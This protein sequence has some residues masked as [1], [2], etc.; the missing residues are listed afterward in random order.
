MTVLVNLIFCRIDN[1]DG[2]IFGGGGG[3]NGR[4]YGGLMF[5]MLLGLR[6]CGAHI[7]GRLIYGGVLTE[8]YGTCLW[9]A[10]SQ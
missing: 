7:C 2:P 8:F 3:G 1:S 9:S 10:L 6:I 4:I 5:G